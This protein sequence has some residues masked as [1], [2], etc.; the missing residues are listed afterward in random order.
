MLTDAKLRSLKPKDAIYRVADSQGLCIAIRPLGPKIWRYRY[1]FAAKANMFSLGEYSG[2]TLAQARS[3]RDKHR[4]LVKAGSDPVQVARI[5]RAAQVERTGNTFAVLADELMEKRAKKLT[6]GS[7]V[8]ERRLLERDL[9]SV[10]SADFWGVCRSMKSVRHCFSRLYARSR[11]AGLLR[12]RTGR[13]QRPHSSSAMR[14]RRAARQRTR[15]PT[16]R[17]RW[18]R[19]KRNTSRASPSQRMSQD[20]CGRSGVTKDCPSFLWR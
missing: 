10:I 5:Q 20:C 14:S 18:R 17:E 19:Q 3:E 12:P 4:A 7:V 8:R 1:R 11:R 2:V 6:P 9:G 16:W 15:R 13:V